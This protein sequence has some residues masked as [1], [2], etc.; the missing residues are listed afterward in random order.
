[1]EVISRS[2]NIRMSPRKLRLVADAV[3]GLKVSQALEILPQLGKKAFLPLFLT[4]KQGIGNAVNNF[5]LDKENLVIKKLEIGKGPT[6]KRGRAISRGQY[7][8]IL[9]RTSHLTMVLE[10]KPASVPPLAKLRRGK[11][12]AKNGTKS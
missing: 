6:L 7:H 12:G 4:L 2:S 1:M 11:K 8:S 5:K 9:K 10:G 3:R